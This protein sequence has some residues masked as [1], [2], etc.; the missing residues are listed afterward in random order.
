MRA[1]HRNNNRRAPQGCRASEPGLF[2]KVECGQ[3][4]GELDGLSDCLA[5]SNAGR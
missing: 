5:F 4:T 1:K 3:R 2:A